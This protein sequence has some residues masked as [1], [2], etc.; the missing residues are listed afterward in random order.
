MNTNLL[1]I[2]LHQYKNNSWNKI[3]L[4]ENRG[5]NIGTQEERMR[6]FTNL[7]I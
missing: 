2:A 4:I 6:V 3:K 1:L 5:Y 7:G